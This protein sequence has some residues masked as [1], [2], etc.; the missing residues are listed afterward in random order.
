MHPNGVRFL[1]IFVSQAQ[2]VDGANGHLL[3]LA[4]FVCPRLVLET[5]VVA[6][7]TGRSAFLFWAS[8]PIKVQKNV[9]KTTVSLSSTTRVSL[10]QISCANQKQQKEA[11]LFLLTFELVM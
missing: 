8:E 10:R 9:T 3:W 1:L 5:S 2:V 7:S 4:E 11:V 6:T